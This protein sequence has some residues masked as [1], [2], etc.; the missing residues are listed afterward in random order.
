M[1]NKHDWN[2]LR[3][4][5]VE[6]LPDESDPGS[7][8]WLS[9]K[10]LGEEYG[11]PWASVRRR[12]SRE[13][14]EQQRLLFRQRIEDSRRRERVD[15]LGAQA[16]SVDAKALKAAET[17]LDLV[18]VGLNTMVRRATTQQQAGNSAQVD[19]LELDRL[20]RAA[21]TWHKIAHV[22]MGDEPAGATGVA[23]DVAASVAAAGLDLATLPTDDLV[24]LRAI[25]R[26]AMKGGDDDERSGS[27]SGTQN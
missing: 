14:W 20:G 13:G 3:R 24:A 5:F 26:K 25:V 17:G 6:G 11:I 21:A 9:Q 23:P 19:P 8:R 18:R 16:A 22:A 27:V 15:H 7:V 12:A 4:V 10:Q 2:D 1:P